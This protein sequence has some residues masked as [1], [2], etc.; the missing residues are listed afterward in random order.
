VYMMIRM[1]NG[2]PMFIFCLIFFSK[3]F[4]FNKKNADFESI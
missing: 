3:C 4:V 2:L 1:A